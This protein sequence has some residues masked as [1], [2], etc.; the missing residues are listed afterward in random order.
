MKGCVA[1]GDDD[2]RARGGW[3]SGRGDHKRH[4]G[5]DRIRG[6]N[7]RDQLTGRGGAD[8]LW[9]LRGADTL[10]GD[11]G[12]DTI[13]TGPKDESARDVVDA[14]AG[15]D[16]VR[17]FKRPASKDVID[18]GPGRDRVTADSRD[19]PDGCNRVSRP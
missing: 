19:V 10:N 13:Y 16:V 11:S 9:G 7:A 3:R 2:G 18:C 5:D 15:N 6:T 1:R 4:Q 14:S 8:V 17:A 12:R